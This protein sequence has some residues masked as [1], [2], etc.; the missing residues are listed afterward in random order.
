MGNN[1]LNQRIS[2]KKKKNQQNNNTSILWRRKKK[3]RHTDEFMVLTIEAK[4][5]FRDSDWVVVNAREEDSCNPESK[6]EEELF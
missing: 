6:S 1:P 4:I 3:D 5:E 2:I